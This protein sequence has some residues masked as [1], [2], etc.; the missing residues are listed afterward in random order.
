MLSSE[1]GWNWALFSLYRQQFPRFEERSQSCICTLFL[2][3]GVKLKLIVA[4][5]T[6]IFEIR[7]NFQT[8]HIWAWNLDFE[9]GSQSCIIYVLSFY[10]RESKLILFSLY[11]H[12]F[13]RYRVIFKISIFGHEIWN[14]KKGPKVA[15]VFSFYRRRSK[16]S[17]YLLYWQPFSR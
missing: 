6:A 3:Q 2:A 12:P 8:L 16:L 1:A 7:A 9:D 14:S 17:L 5:W 4:L 13:S 11:G 15:Y 10:P